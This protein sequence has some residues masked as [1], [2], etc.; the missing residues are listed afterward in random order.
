MKAGGLGCCEE[1][2]TCRKERPIK[3]NIGS[4]L[5]LIFELSGSHN[6]FLLFSVQSFEFIHFPRD[7]RMS[8]CLIAD[9]RLE[10]INRLFQGYMKKRK[11][12][13]KKFNAAANNCSAQHE[14]SYPILNSFLLSFI[15]SL[16]PWRT[17]KLHLFRLAEKSSEKRNNVTKGP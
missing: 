2:L 15:F 10:L 8:W 12:K 6:F 13:K 9:S 14:L 4:P 17:C 7:L 3:N 16:S 5:L 11:R 1:H